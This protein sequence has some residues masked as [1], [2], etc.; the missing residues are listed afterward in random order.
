MWWAKRRAINRNYYGFQRSSSAGLNNINTSPGVGGRSSKGLGL[1]GSRGV[2]NSRRLSARASTH[3]RS[4]T[5]RFSF[6]LLFLDLIATIGIISQLMWT[7]AN[8]LM[9]SLPSAL[10]NLCAVWTLYKEI[11]GLSNANTKL[12]DMTLSRVDG[13]NLLMVINIAQLVPWTF[14][15]T[16][17]V[18]F[19]CV[20]LMQVRAIPKCMRLL[21]RS[22]LVLDAIFFVVGIAGGAAGRI[23]L[24]WVAAAYGAFAT[25]IP[26]SILLYQ[27]RQNLSSF[28]RAHPFVTVS[29]NVAAKGVI[30]QLVYIFIGS[31]FAAAI[32]ISTV[33]LSKQPKFANL[34]WIGASTV[35]TIISSLAGVAYLIIMDVDHI[36][37]EADI[38][39]DVPV[40][41]VLPLNV[42][43]MVLKLL[44]SEEVP[45]EPMDD[46]RSRRSSV[47][48]LPLNSGVSGPPISPLPSASTS[49]APYFGP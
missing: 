36:F 17:V 28:R 49:R 47:T 10:R 38:R 5:R 24:I 33:F 26:V 44:P 9:W 22:L 7:L 37:R 8:A 23:Q 20:L 15:M 46:F 14:A 45:P 1:D 29:T 19:C 2:D 35:F 18:A 4:R 25:S 32:I 6:L 42:A 16:I 48:S 43:P 34:I 12:S 40:T 30:R 3:V 39:V 21:Y 27:L 41:I 11:L 13:V 31:W